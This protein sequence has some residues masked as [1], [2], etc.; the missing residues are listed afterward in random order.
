MVR[1]SLRA[2]FHLREIHDH[3]KPDSP[4]YAKKVVRDIVRKCKTIPPYPLVGRMVP[5]VQDEKIREIFE[6]SYRL[7]YEIVGE[8]EIN[9]LAIVHFARD[10]KEL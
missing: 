1:F 4:F 9:V 10:F 3:I 2:R 7:I 5:E 6:Y 8:N